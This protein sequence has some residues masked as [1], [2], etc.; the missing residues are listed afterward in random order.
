MKFGIMV[1]IL[2]ALI[3][4][5]CQG[6][7]DD[8]VVFCP[9]IYDPVC[10]SDGVT[11]GNSCEA[12]RA[13]VTEYTSGECGGTDIPNQIDVCPAVYDPVCGSDGVTYENSCVA[14]REGVFDYTL[15]ECN[16]NNGLPGP[17]EVCPMIYAPVCG[18][19]PMPE[20]PPGMACPQVM[21]PPQTYSNDCFMELA[22]AEFLY[23]GE[24]DE[25]HV[26]DGIVFCTPQQKAADFCTMEYNPV[27]GDNGVTYSNPCVGCSSSEIDYY[28][29]GECA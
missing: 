15:G 20:C 1:L 26:N 13:G 28:T 14:E 4:A 19:P 25:E 21:P 10:G 22:G 16:G 8:D 18:Q 27:C 24:C 17:I 23:E 3:V 2:A 12:E 11:Y 6:D 9:T 7:R 29:M 5:G